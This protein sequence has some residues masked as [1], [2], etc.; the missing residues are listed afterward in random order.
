[1]PHLPHLPHT[2][3]VALAFICQGDCILLVHNRDVRQG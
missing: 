2:V 1:M 3:I